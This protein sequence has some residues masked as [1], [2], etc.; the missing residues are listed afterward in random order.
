MLAF[1]EA[2]RAN[3]VAAKI[4]QQN[5]TVAFDAI[6]VD[7]MKLHPVIHRAILKEAMVRGAEAAAAQFVSFAIALDEGDGTHD[8]KANILRDIY[9][10]RAD[11]PY[12]PRQSAWAER[13]SPNNIDGADGA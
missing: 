1:F 8:E 13:P 5:L 9:R 6:G 11:G 3:L 4:A 10:V 7:Y 2:A 12:T